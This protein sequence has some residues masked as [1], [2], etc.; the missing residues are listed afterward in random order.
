MLELRIDCRCAVSCE[1]LIYAEPNNL[2]Y[3]LAI[4]IAL[5]A[6]AAPP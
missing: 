2:Q 1:Y 3:T 6:F 5:Y 4:G